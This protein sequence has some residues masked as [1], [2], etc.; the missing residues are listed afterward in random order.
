VR[1]VEVADGHMLLLWVRLDDSRAE[2][3]FGLDLDDSLDEA[4]DAG[5]DPL[6]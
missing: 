5:L 2:V 3:E 6:L 4:G 1:W